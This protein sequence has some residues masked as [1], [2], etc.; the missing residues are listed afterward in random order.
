MIQCNLTGFTGKFVDEG[1][2]RIEDIKD[3]TKSKLTELGYFRYLKDKNKV[4]VKVNKDLEGTEDSKCSKNQ[5]VPQAL[6]K[7]SKSDRNSL[8]TQSVNQREGQ[9]PTWTWIF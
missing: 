8:G 6:K 5:N 2:P 1:V 7:I 9:C 3:L 4:Q